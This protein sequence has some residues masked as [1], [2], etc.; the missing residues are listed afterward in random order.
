MRRRS[1]PDFASPEAARS[2]A[3]AARPRPCRSPLVVRR[4]TLPAPAARKLA[5]V[6]AVDEPAVELYDLGR[7][8]GE[9]AALRGVTV[10]VPAGATLAVFGPNGA[11]RSTLLRLL[12]TLLRPHRG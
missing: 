9:R 12:A 5:P 1:C 4:T 8:Y 6:A 11:G 3:C 10:T 2:P 7:D